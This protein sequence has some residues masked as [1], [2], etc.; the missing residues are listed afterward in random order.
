VN[1][2]E[3]VDRVVKFSKDTPALQM[4]LNAIAMDM[5]DVFRTTHIKVKDAA[6]FIKEWRS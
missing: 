3:L 5:E 4:L 2:K 1:D 6:T